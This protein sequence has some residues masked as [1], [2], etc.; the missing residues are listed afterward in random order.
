MLLFGIVPNGSVGIVADMG[1]DV[2]VDIDVDVDVGADIVADAGVGWL[3]YAF[4]GWVWGL[5]E[6]VCSATAL[7][8]MF[9]TACHAFALLFARRMRDICSA[10]KARCRSGASNRG[11]RSSDKMCIIAW[12][13]AMAP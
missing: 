3:M 11:L 7:S 13:E 1:V 5:G 9:L 6:R 2:G 4:K 8:I 12:N 10:R